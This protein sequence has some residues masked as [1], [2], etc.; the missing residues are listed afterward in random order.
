MAPLQALPND[1]YTVGWIYAL[2]SEMAAAEAMMDE[3]HESIQ[4]PALSDNN[5]CT[6]V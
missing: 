4:G 3:I 5:S 2:P 6:L 1:K